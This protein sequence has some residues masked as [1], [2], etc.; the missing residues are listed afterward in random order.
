MIA[1]NSL[2]MSLWLQLSSEL[3]LAPISQHP[4]T[5]I[6]ANGL[7]DEATGISPALMINNIKMITKSILQSFKCREEG[8]HVLLLLPRNRHSTN[9][10]AFSMFSNDAQM[11]PQIILHKL[12]KPFVKMIHSQMTDAKHCLPWY[13]HCL[14][15]ISYHLHSQCMDSFAMLDE[16]KSVLI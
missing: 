15:N 6:T 10:P 11:H 8:K 14:L 7:P 5:P 16:Y 1:N 9:H 12:M 13:C 4:L 3:T 2:I